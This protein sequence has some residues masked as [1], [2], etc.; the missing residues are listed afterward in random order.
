MIDGFIL[1]IQLYT[2]IPIK[3][4]V[5]FSK[6]NLKLALFFL[7]VM[8]ALIG[9][10]TGL[11]VDL[12]GRGDMFLAGAL[13]LVTYIILSGGLHLDGLADMADGYLSNTNPERT[14]EIMKDSLIGAFGTIALIL[15][16]ILKTALYGAFINSA[17]TYIVLSSMIS[18]FSVLYLIKKGKLARP[19]GFGAKMKEALENYNMTLAFYI[20]FLTSMVILIGAKYLFVPVICFFVNEFI[21]F[22]SNN[23][24]NGVTGDIYGAAIEINELVA[25]LCFWGLQ[26]I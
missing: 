24:I 5:E 12:V 6:E 4:A 25:L 17:F 10:I 1:S 9:T 19:G 16:C 21:L 15:Y 20:V 14:L 26:W 3:K 23:K 18:R 2:R 11:V 8:G 13:G 22:I 7:P